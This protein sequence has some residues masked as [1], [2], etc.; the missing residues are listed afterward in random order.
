M[1]SKTNNLPEITD[2]EI[3]KLKESA[4]FAEKGKTHFTARFLVIGGQ[5]TPEQLRAAATIAQRYGNG[6][7]H[8]TTRQ[9]FEIPHIPYEKLPLMRKTL[10]KLPIEPARSGKCVRSIVACPGTYCKFGGID[11]QRLAHDISRKFGKRKNLPHKFKIA[12][13]GCRHCCAKPQENDLGV[14]GVGKNFAVFVGGMAGKTP[15]WGDRLPL[16]LQN[17]TELLALIKVI[18]DWYAAHG[19]D[20]ERFGATIERVGLSNMLADIGQ[21]P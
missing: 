13:T 16:T 4:I 15:R 6:T 3:A 19:L 17:K 2:A 8:L 20:K 14:L 12:V 1:S 5:M 21:S 7:V 9:G 10:E 18:I 11:T